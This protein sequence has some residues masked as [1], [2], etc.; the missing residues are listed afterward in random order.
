MLDLERSGDRAGEQEVVRLLSLLVERVLARLGERTKLVSLTGQRAQQVLAGLQPLHAEPVG[1]GQTLD[2]EVG[3]VRVALDLPGV[4]LWSQEPGV[5]AR[6]GQG[7][8]HQVGWQHDAGRNA[9]GPGSGVAHSGRVTG[10]VV[11]RGD[12]VEE[13]PRLR[14]AGQQLVSGVQV[15]V[16]LVRQGPDDGELVRPRR[17]SGEVLAEHHAGG[18]RLDRAELAPNALGRLGLHVE[19]VEMPQAAGHEHQDHRLRPRPGAGPVLRPSLIR[20]GRALAREQSR[21]AQSQEPG[22]SHLEELPA[23]D[24]VGMGV[25]GPH[26]RQSFPSSLGRSPVAH[27]S[28][29]SQCLTYLQHTPERPFRQ[30]T[31]ASEGGW[32]Y[33]EIEKTPEADA[34]LR[35]GRLPLLMR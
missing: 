2:L 1:Q 3:A 24:S 9:V 34:G 21:R 31:L 15:V 26:G 23:H 22:E 8:F 19:R 7:A 25:V 28:G 27:F 17:H 4:V 14:V 35:G 11:A 5:L 6:P 10:V 16:V 20:P 33:F 18:G 13:R 32:T 29:D 30:A 12:L